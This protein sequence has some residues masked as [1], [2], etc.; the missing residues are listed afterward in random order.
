MTAGTN[1]LPPLGHTYRL[2]TL[3]GVR[4]ALQIKKLAGDTQLTREEVIAY[5]KWWGSLAPAVR[6][7]LTATRQAAEE[8]AAERRQV[9][10]QQKEE[11][12][13]E[14]VRK[15]Q[16]YQGGR[17]ACPHANC[18]W[19]YVCVW[20]AQ[21]QRLRRALGLPA[22]EHPAVVPLRVSDQIPSL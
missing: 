3:Q 12:R 17:F 2:S 9:L 1:P 13:Q 20:P 8:A 5:F 18:R 21:R 14:A 16:A 19:F 15:N 22:R 10:A 6:K 11:A 7:D 4:D